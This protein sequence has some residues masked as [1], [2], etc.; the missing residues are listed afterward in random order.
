MVYLFLRKGASFISSAAYYLQKVDVVASKNA[1][2]HH[3]KRA[4][5]EASAVLINKYTF[6]Y[7]HEKI[8]KNTIE[9]RIRKNTS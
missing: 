4:T 8:Q 6:N 7:D 5:I 2:P 1:T 9:F 3:D